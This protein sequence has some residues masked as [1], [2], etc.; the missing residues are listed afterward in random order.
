MPFSPALEPVTADDDAIRAAL[1]GAML[2]ALLPALAHATGDL[3]LLRDDLRPDPLRMAEPDAG[4]SAEQAATIKAIALDA[5]RRFRDGGCMVAAT[6]AHEILHRL[7]EHTVGGPVSPAYLPLLEEELSITGEDLREPGWRLE[8]VAPGRSFSVVIVGAGMSGVLA[9]HR[10]QQ[11][12][13]PFVI[14]EK[15]ADVGGTWWEN[16]YPGCRVDNPNHIYSYSFAQRHEWPF[17]NSPQPVL[18]EYFRGFVRDHDLVQHIRFGTRVS[19]ITWDDERAGWTVRATTA[20]GDEQTIEADAVISAVGQLNVPRLPD[21]PGLDRFAGPAFHSATWDH[22]V[23]LAGKRVAVIG[24]GASACQLIP[25]VAAAAAH[26]TVFQRNAPWLVFNAH[27]MEPVGD[28]LRWLYRHV[29]F[30][31]EWHRFWMFWRTGDGMLD[32]ARVDPDWPPTETSVSAANELMRQ[33]LMGYLEMAFADRPDLLAK[34]TPAYPPVAKRVVVDNGVLPRALMRDDVDLVT[35]PIREITEHGVVT[36]DGV[37][38]PVDVLILGTGFQAANFLGTLQVKGRHGTDLHEQWAGDARAY[39]GVTIP[40]FPNLFCCYGPNT[41]IVINAS[42]IYFVECEVRYILG[43]LEMLLR[44]GARALDV[45]RTVHDEFN[46]R[47]DAQNRRMAWGFSKV[48]SWYKNEHGRVAQ[49]WPFSLLEFWQLT[50][51]PEPD[52][53]AFL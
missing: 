27:Y 9:G 25:P 12:G 34:M 48:S 24:T 31:S 15:N 33:L 7:M 19:S 23:D 53:Y 28:G 18:L 51:H 37:E 42:T 21:I 17:H 45:D 39:L 40:D 32:L 50:R 20:D 26:L 29:P 5:I 3:S 22:D 11:A 1:D 52:D 4:L 16:T 6:P 2:P 30:Y 43:C 41:N 36:H 8:D 49:N 47:V 35:T 14:L 10:L 38:H 13:I 44:R 46:V